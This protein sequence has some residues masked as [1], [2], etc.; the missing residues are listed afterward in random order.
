[1]SEVQWLRREAAPALAW[2]LHRP[3][4]EVRG[5]VLIIHGYKDH[6][7]RYLHVVQEWLGRGLLVGRLDLRGHGHSEGRRGDLRQFDDYLCDARDVLTALERHPAWRAESPP[8]VFGHSVG[9]LVALQL[10][11]RERVRYRALA[12]SSPFLALA[13][14]APAWKVGLGKLLSGVAPSFALDSGLTVDMQT[15]CPEMQERIRTDR[16][17]FSKAR[18]RWFTE[19]LRAQRDVARNVDDLELPVFCLAAGADRIAD[20]QRTREVLGR[21]PNAE[22]RVLN[23]HQHEI[24]HEVRRAA[25]V[26]TFGEWIQRQFAC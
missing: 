13:L 18:A 22:L 12:L 8:V 3:T 25:H 11:L 16:L 1:M 21:M 9:A 15:S 5:A 4:G 14:P 10:V 7:G 19:T 26:A 6:S 2:A 23:D 17:R 24:L 20:V